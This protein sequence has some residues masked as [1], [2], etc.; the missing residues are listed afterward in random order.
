MICVFVLFFCF[1]AFVFLH[2]NSKNKNEIRHMGLKIWI[3]HGVCF[4][5]KSNMLLTRSAGF[6]KYR[7]NYSQTNVFFMTP[8]IFL[9]IYLNISRI[10][11]HTSCSYSFNFT[12][13]F[14]K[15]YVTI[16]IIV[17]PFKRNNII[18]RL[19]LMK[20]SIRTSTSSR[21]QLFK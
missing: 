3:F 2:P 11:F 15:H 20:M 13:W 12:W 10:S 7:F 1:F 18:G 19:S 8:H 9:S 21:I 4:C 6:V 14:L 17:R 5:G 16:L